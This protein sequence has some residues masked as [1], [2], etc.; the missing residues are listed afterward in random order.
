MKYIKYF[1][2]Y[3]LVDKTLDELTINIE[4]QINEFFNR[5]TPKLKEMADNLNLKFRVDDISNRFEIGGSNDK[6]I[7]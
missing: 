7:L 2:G 3:A 4:D 5:I 6:Y 1:E